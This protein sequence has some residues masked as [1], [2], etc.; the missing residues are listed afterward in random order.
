MWD[1]PR[2]DAQERGAFFDDGRAM[3]SRV[4]GTVAREMEANLEHTTGRDA[5][6]D[7]WV[8]EV[9]R[10]IV[11]EAGGMEQLVRRGQDRYGIHCAPCHGL[12]GHGDGMVARRAQELGA[13]ALMPP[14]LHNSRL[15]HVPDGQIYAT[16][17]NGIRNMPAYRH[18]VPLEDRWAIVSYVRALQMSQHSGKQAMNTQGEKPE[19]KP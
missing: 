17:T 11:R 1:Q 2:Y 15:R 16:I 7:G 8:R 6:G 13:A 4:P 9:P 3:R 19:A 10:Q 14:T 5:Q 18:N 12:S